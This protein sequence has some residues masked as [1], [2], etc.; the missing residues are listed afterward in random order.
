MDMYCNTKR[1]SLMSYV[2]D[3]YER[4]ARLRALV[5]AS[6]T[7]CFNQIRMYRHM[8]D[9]LC[10]MLDRIGGLRPTKN[11]LVDEPVPEDS[12]G[13]RWKWFKGCL[14]AIDGTHIRIKVPLEVQEKYRNR[15]GEI[16]TNVLGVCSRDGQFV[17]VLSGWEGSTADERVLKDAME[18]DDGLKVP[19][20]SSSTATSSKIN[21]IWT[22]AEDKLLVQSMLSLMEN[23]Q[24]YENDTFKEKH[25]GKLEEMMEA[26]AP[27][28]GLK[29]TPTSQAE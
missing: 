29:A 2:Y 9:R 22:S 13:E 14:G 7:T 11:M 12:T 10:G 21:H 3:S 23:P 8:F 19:R 6:D 26:K 27:C 18:R 5:Y 28:C 17:Y 25:L 16:T 1:I 20:E 4:G 15:K 24:Y